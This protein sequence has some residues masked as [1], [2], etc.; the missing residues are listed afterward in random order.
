MNKN[1]AEKYIVKNFELF[2][3]NCNSMLNRDLEDMRC[4]HCNQLIDIV[5]A[6][7]GL[8]CDNVDCP[9]HD[10]LTGCRELASK[11]KNKRFEKHSY[12]I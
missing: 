2:C 1:I 5:S 3:P 9:N 8:N 10:Y 6:P 7:V 12:R 4:Y 11:C